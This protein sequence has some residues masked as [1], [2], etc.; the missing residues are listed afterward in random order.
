MF[1]ERFFYLLE[2]FANFLFNS[3]DRLLGFLEY[4]FHLAD[5]LDKI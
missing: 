2:A 1:C 4:F 3:T 5:Y